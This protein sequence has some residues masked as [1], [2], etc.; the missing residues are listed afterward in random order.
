VDG[1]GWEVIGQNC[2]HLEEN[3]ELENRKAW[4]YPLE[5][6]IEEKEENVTVSQLPSRCSLPFWLRC[7]LGFFSFS[8]ARSFEILILFFLG[9]F[10][11]FSFFGGRGR[12]LEAGS[13]NSS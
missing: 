9:V 13:P 5:V 6:E 11:Y 3:G 7:A 1:K 12:K 2:E 4:G 10:N 8:R